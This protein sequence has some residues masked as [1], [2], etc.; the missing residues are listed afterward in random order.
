MKRVGAEHPKIGYPGPSSRERLQAGRVGPE[1]IPVMLLLRLVLLSA[2]LI[3]APGIRAAPPGDVAGLP[4][5]RWGMTEAEL[6]DALGGRMRRLPGRQVYGGAYADYQLPGVEIGGERFVGFL[7]M[8]AGTARLQ[9]L[10]LRSMRRQPSANAHRAV[11]RALRDRY[12]PEDLVCR[13]LKAGR[14]D[15]VTEYVWQF[16]TTIVHFTLLDFYTTAMAFQDPNSN[17]DPL[18]PMY[19]RERNNPRFLPR[20]MLVR[21]HPADRSD[22]VGRGQ[23]A[24][25][26]RTP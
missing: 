8:E 20:A 1:S 13:E 15:L 10:L 16:P 11:L 17:R 24:E 12:G 22:L 6:L 2:L 9:Q 25:G 14:G 21:L 23:C 19:K 4:G 26:K 3:A 18:Q 5:T 7:Q